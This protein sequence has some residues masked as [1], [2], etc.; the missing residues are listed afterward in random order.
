M[1]S[2]SEYNGDMMGMYSNDN[3]L[4][5]KWDGANILFSMCRQGN[6][7]M[8]NFASDKKSLRKLREAIDEFID[9]MFK[10]FDW[11]EMILAEIKLRSVRKLVEKL[12]F[13]FLDYFDDD[14]PHDAY[15]LTREEYY[16]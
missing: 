2:F 4:N 8:C 1:M 16:G 11:C 5:F 12:G 9:F 6:A 10:S 13:K 3:H 7:V 15:Y 14:N